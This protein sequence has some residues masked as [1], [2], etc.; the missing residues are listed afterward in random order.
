MSWVTAAI[1]YPVKSAAFLADEAYLIQAGG[2][3]ME[4]ASIGSSEMPSLA[5]AWIAVAVRYIWFDQETMVK[6]LSL[7]LR[8]FDQLSV[9]SGPFRQK[10]WDEMVIQRSVR[11]VL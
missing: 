3:P 9:R 7:L 11:A 1:A 6:S 10:T 4:R 2:A 5:S 8:I